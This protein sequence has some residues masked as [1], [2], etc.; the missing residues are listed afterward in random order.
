MAAAAELGC[1]GAGAIEVTGEG[2]G[3][4]KNGEEDAGKLYRGLGEADTAGKGPD[5]AGDVGRWGRER[6][7]GI[8]I[9]S[10]PSRAHA[11]AGEAG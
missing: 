5:L 11:R 4:G 6:E 9:E 2:G 1:D 3:K 10:C 8:Q 7:G